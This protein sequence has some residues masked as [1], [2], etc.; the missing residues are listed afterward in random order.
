M[1]TWI[2]KSAP[3]DT[4]SPTFMPLICSV[5][6]GFHVTFPDGY[7]EIFNSTLFG[8]EPF[9]NFKEFQVFLKDSVQRQIGGT[10]LD[11]FKR[12]R[13]GEYHFPADLQE[14]IL[15]G[16]KPHAFDN[17]YV[18]FIIKLKQRLARQQCSLVETHGHRGHHTGE[19][20][21]E[22]R[23]HHTGEAH[24]AEER[25][26]VWYV[27]GDD[28]T[29]IPFDEETN[30]QINLCVDFK[31][32]DVLK[33]IGKFNYLIDPTA[34]TQLNLQTGTI[35]DI[36][37]KKLETRPVKKW[38]YINDR[39]IKIPFS[40][41][42]NRKIEAG[43]LSGVNPRLHGYDLYLDGSFQVNTDGETQQLI[44]EGGNKKT[45]RKTKRNKR[46]RSIYVS[47]RHSV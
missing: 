32:K 38:H 43:K 3:D 4:Q 10:S 20:H 8:S 6:D 33:K 28:G 41:E 46:R 26:S 39:G 16:G 17:F 15:G 47:T 37:E 1:T 2:I 18:F 9:R 5:I 7:E 36:V 24:R 34:K 35:R 22:H 12:A 40:E 44:Y 42:D 30:T 27:R 45:K 21:R 25:P 31:Q 23:G 11:H 29:L 19:A 13:D 14:R